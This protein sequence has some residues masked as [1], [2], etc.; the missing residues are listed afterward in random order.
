MVNHPLGHDAV[1]VV[2]T[3]TF[4]VNSAIGAMLTL[5]PLA[6][7]ATVADASVMNANVG[8]TR[9]RRTN[10]GIECLLSLSAG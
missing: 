8:S 10:L 6:A 1:M 2:T 4:A 5:T 7:R 3:S 9:A